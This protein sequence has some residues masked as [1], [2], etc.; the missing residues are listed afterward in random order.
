[1]LSYVAGEALG[2]PTVKLLAKP[3]PVLCLL[4]WLAPWP[5]GARR[6]VAAGLLACVAGDVLLELP[7]R[8][9][10]GLSAFLLGHVAYL[11]AFVDA[12]RVVNP[13][14][15]A[16][17]AAWGLSAY[18][19]L[20]PGLGAMAFPVGLYVCVIC[21]MMWRASALLGTRFGARGAIGAILFGL[22]DTLIAFDRFHEPIAGVR[23]PIILLYWAGQLG[24]AAWAH[25]QSRDA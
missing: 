19:F 13:W 12:R 3:I 21:A 18:V 11:K 4:L 6:F 25:A 5:R 1:M 17:F 9:V 14:R 15:L 20:F 23:Y 16:G 10:A 24:I 22:S 8:F 2:Q 7:G